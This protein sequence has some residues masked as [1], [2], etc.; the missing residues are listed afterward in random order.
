MFYICKME[1]RL[2]LWKHYLLCESLMTEVQL[3]SHSCFTKQE[4]L[5]FFLPLEFLSYLPNQNFLFFFT[6]FIQFIVY[7]LRLL[8]ASQDW[9]RLSCNMCP[10]IH[11]KLYFHNEELK[12]KLHVFCHLPSPPSRR[13]LSVFQ[14]NSFYFPQWVQNLIH[15]TPCISV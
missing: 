5:F 7:V 6:T 15:S 4:Q 13:I 3:K 12:T 10:C 8:P 1:I 2:Q 9:D 14:I 11:W